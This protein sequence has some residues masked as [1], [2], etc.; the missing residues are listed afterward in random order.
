MPQKKKSQT[1]STKSNS[2]ANAKVQPKILAKGA[3]K[4]QAPEKTKKAEPVVLAKAGKVAAK[5]GK[6]QEAP[7]HLVL[8]K[9]AEVGKKKG[10]LTFEEINSALPKEMNSPEQLEDAIGMFAIMLGASKS[11]QTLQSKCGH[12]VG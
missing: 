5:K 3:T 6:A 2:K 7:A 4:K 8:E 10:F 1:V 9:L 12:R 11:G